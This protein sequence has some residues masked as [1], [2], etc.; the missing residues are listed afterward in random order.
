VPD[1]QDSDS[2]GDGVSDLIES[3]A[4][5][6]D[7]DGRADSLVA[8]TAP[9]EIDSNNAPDLNQANPDHLVL[10][11]QTGQ[12]C[13]VGALN[14]SG[15]FDPLFLLMLGFAMMCCLRVR[16]GRLRS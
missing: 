13:S 1:F 15:R 16:Q 12:G 6:L 5:D 8:Q 10:T 2:N 9:D 11:G 7:G 14:T 4:P 3:G